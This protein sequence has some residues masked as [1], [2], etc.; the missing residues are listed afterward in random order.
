MTPVDNRPC[1]DCKAEPGE[2]HRE[3]DYIARCRVTGLQL[4][5]CGPTYDLDDDGEEILV[6]ADHE[7][8]PDI[9][10]GEFPGVKRCREFG[11]F[12][13]DPEFGTT[14]DINRLISAWWNPETETWDARP[15]GNIFYGD[16]THL[17]YT[18]ERAKGHVGLHR[19]VSDGQGVLWYGE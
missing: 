12:K 5:A 4:V 11:W 8:G 15:C 10:D 17:P 3:W 6:E 2:R 1:P 14:E 13:D 7:C 9:W 18:C 19:K 16:N